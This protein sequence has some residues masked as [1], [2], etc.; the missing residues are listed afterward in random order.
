DKA[1]T[2]Q[3]VHRARVCVAK[4]RAVSGRAETRGEIRESG[5]LTAVSSW[6]AVPPRP[7]TPHPP[8]CN[9][10]GWIRGRDGQGFGTPGLFMSGLGLP[11]LP[12]RHQGEAAGG[13]HLARL[14]SPASLASLAPQILRA[15][16]G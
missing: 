9:S 8:H 3:S 6:P 4:G 2:L 16:L 13:G 14:A 1:T 10:G 11:A 15:L 7:A 12:G 5:A